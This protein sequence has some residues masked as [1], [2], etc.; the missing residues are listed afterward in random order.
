MYLVRD[1]KTRILFSSNFSMHSQFEQLK[2][3]KQTFHWSKTLKKTCL[4]LVRK[5]RG[6]NKGKQGWWFDVTNKIM[7]GSYLYSQVPIKQVGPNK[8]VG[9]IFYVNFLSK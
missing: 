3:K 4:F 8:Q 9:W 5:I 7:I 6:K 2:K 1:I